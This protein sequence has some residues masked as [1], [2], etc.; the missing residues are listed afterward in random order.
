[1]RRC[2]MNNK[3][4]LSVIVPVYGV[5][6]YI[7]QCLDSIISQTYKNLEIIVINDGTKDASAKIAKGYARKDARIKVYD[8]E[9]GGLSVARN[10]GLQLANGEY[11]AFLDSDD[12]LEVDA[13]QVCME[14]MQKY[15]LDFVKFGVRELCLET[16]TEK[17]F[18]FKNMIIDA[19][20]IAEKYFGNFL[21]VV[22]WNAVYKR[23]IALSVEYPPKLVNED[24]Y[25]SGMY[26]ALARK[27]MTIDKVLYNYRVNFDGISKGKIKRPLDK[28]LVNMKLCNDLKNMDFVMDKYYYKY[29]C[30]VYHFIRGW[31][32]SYKVKSI[33]KNLYTFVMQHLDFRRKVSLYW[34][35]FKRKISIV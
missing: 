31:N 29:A 34:I 12:Y 10:R 25:A 28:C 24:N 13:Y 1:M 18:A 32:S 21:C 19:P 9:N 17:R 5:E 30:E 33:E 23:N 6:K 15:N 7:A 14:Y 27:I 20:D 16:G 26:F 8:F 2:V 4:L 35:I 22:V 11:I 3:S